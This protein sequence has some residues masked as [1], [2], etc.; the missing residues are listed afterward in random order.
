MKSI[1]FLIPALLVVHM[2]HGQQ[3]LK[4]GL[5]D[6][7][8]GDIIQF[9]HVQNPHQQVGTLT[10]K[11]GLFNI[12]ATAGDTIIFSIVGYQTTG[13]VVGT[14]FFDS[15]QWFEIEQDTMWLEEV[16]VSR[17][18]PEEVFKRELLG[19]E[20]EDTSFWYHG[21]PE[22]VFSGDKTLDERHVSNPLFL[23]SHPITGWHYKF[24]K[25]EKERR[26]M[27]RIDQSK[28]GRNRVRFK[29]T[30]DWVG[31][32]TR[33]S[34]DSL[35]SFIEFCSYEQEYLEK[36]PLYMIQEDMLAKLAQF[37]KGEVKG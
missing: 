2:V 4:G 29:F 15:L 25:S 3:L 26:K 8:S 7:T 22:P 23:L 10:N 20:L 34:G 35:T 13:W 19:L 18:P 28:H 16:I 37:L 32:V 17:V 27:H 36:T 11:S 9:A 33:L 6:K 14:S 21:V 1:C 31:E 30:R 12:P 5:K 24:S